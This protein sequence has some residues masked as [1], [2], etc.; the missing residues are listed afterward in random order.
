MTIK[1]ITFDKSTVTSLDDAVVYDYLCNEGGVI[2]GCEVTNPTSNTLH[3]ANGHGV[4]HGRKFTV[5][6]ETIN[7]SLPASNQNGRLKIKIDLSNNE[8]PIQLV[9]EMT[10]GEL[11]P[12]KKDHDMNYTNGIYEYELGTFKAIPQGINSFKQTF[13]ASQIADIYKDVQMIIKKNQELEKNINA[14]H[15]VYK[16]TSDPTTNLGK[17]GDVYFQIE[18]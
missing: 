15:K 10:P 13:M 4:I 6:E 3:V 17:D 14:V 5:E 9:V 11:P 16:G 7:V 1:L 8:I 18:V 12:L 2:H